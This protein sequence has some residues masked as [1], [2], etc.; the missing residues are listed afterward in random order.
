MPSRLP[1]F[2]VLSW[3]NFTVTLSALAAGLLNFGDSV[4]RISAAMFSFVGESLH[5]D[6]LHSPPASLNGALCYVQL[7]QSWSMR[8]SHTI[9]VRL[10]FATRE[11][12]HTTTAWVSRRRASCPIASCLIRPVFPTPSGPTVLSVLL[13]IA[14]LVNFI[15]RFQDN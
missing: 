6:P 1:L 12:A 5:R 8:S 4:G 9:G 7:W 3:L 2:P 14:V 10:R 15:L 13:L 11:A